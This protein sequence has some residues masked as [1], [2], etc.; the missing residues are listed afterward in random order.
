ME[1]VQTVDLFENEVPHF[2][3]LEISPEGISI[4]RKGTNIGLYVNYT[5]FVPWAHSTTWIR[6]LVTRALESSINKISQES[7]S[8]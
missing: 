3:D 6:S 2:S 7:I 5:S 4:Y 1:N 8:I